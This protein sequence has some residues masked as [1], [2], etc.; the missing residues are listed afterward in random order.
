[1]RSWSPINQ[2]QHSFL[3]RMAIFAISIL[4]QAVFALL[5]FRRSDPATQAIFASGLC[6]LGIPP[7]PV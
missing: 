1:M 5:V 6:S 3:L 7:Q 2:R 4:P